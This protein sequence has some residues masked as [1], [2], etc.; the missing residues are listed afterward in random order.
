MGIQVGL[1]GRF[2]Q[3][4]QL[5][6]SDPWGLDP[7]VPLCICGD[8]LERI[9]KT[10]RI[11]SLPADLGKDQEHLKCTSVVCRICEGPALSTDFVWTCSHGLDP[12]L[13]P[14]SC[15]VCE[16]CF[17]RC[18]FTEAPKASRRCLG[19]KQQWGSLLH[20]SLLRSG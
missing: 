2:A 7:V 14:D 3:Q 5:K 8:P 11:F 6:Q 15:D 16:A 12:I 19:A 9:E 20:R 10:R 17:D 4:R 1:L 18:V 13:H